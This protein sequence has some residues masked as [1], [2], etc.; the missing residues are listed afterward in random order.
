M[1]YSDI[2]DMIEEAG[3]PFAY[4]HFEDTKQAPPFICYIYTGS[5]DM[6]ADNVNYAKIARLQIELYTDEK[7]PELEQRLEG[8]LKSHDIFYAQAEGYLSSEAMYMHTYT[9]EVVINAE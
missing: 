1:T 4:D 6:A 9:T 2:S 8:I 3:L 7:S 5:A